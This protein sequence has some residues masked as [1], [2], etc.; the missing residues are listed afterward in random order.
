MLT[1]LSIDTSFE[2]IYW[3]IL[4]WFLLLLDFVLG[5]RDLFWVH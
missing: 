1:L 4:D 5:V 3:N 2:N